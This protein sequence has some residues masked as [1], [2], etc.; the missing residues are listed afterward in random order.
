MVTYEGIYQSWLNAG[1]LPEEAQE[2][3]YG[4]S[5]VNVDSLAVYNSRTGRATR[6]SRMDWIRNLTAEGWTLEE[7]MREAREYYYRDAKRSPWDFIKAEYKPRQ[8]KD[9]N[10]YREIQRRRA[11]A[12]IQPLYRKRKPTS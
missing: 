6:V 12:E 11:K 7:I 1:F 2:L 10:E 3:T 4:S 9:F 5:G 8:I